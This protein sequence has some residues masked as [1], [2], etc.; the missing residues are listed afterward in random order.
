VLSSAKTVSDQ[1]LVQRLGIHP[2]VLQGVIQA[3][4]LACKPLA[5]AQ[6][7]KGAPSVCR[8]Q[9]VQCVEEGV[10]ALEEDL[11]VDLLT[12]GDQGVKMVCGRS[13]CVHTV[14]FLP[15]GGFVIPQN[16]PHFI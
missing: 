2:S 4:P 8:E 12:K 14:H 15:R 3:G 7:G 6:V 11:L 5:L 10:S 13:W 9:G 16:L 1:Q